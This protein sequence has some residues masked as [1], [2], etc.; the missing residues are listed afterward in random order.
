VA[1]PYRYVG[2]ENRR[3]PEIATVANASYTLT[4]QVGNA[5]APSG[6]IGK[7]S[8][9]LVYIDGHKAYRA[10]NKKGKGVTHEVWQKFSKTF[11]AKSA[12]TTI[13]FLNGDPLS[14][15]DNGLDCVTLAPAS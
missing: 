5:Y 4:F 13:E 14:D 6:N 12:K 2:Y 10:T 9:I 8:T 15:T 7:S 3:S 1:R 11:T